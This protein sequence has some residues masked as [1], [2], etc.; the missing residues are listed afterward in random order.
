[1]SEAMTPRETVEALDKYIVGQD[2]A[3]CSVAASSTVNSTV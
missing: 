1:M 2:E 3:N